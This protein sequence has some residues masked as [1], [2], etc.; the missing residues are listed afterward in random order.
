M[1]IIVDDRVPVKL[2]ATAADNEYTSYLFAPGVVRTGAQYPLQIHQIAT[3]S[4][5]K[6]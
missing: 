4:A 1:T 3:S 2:G 5:C 6:I